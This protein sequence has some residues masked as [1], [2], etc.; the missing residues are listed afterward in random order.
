MCGE[1]RPAQFQRPVPRRG[2][3]APGSSGAAPLRGSS[4][5]SRRIA[6]RGRAHRPQRCG[7]LWLEERLRRDSVTQAAPACAFGAAGLRFAQSFYQTAAG[8]SG[9]AEGL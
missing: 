7:E 2:A 5:G 3:A 4:I 9:H 8:N 1:L 6:P